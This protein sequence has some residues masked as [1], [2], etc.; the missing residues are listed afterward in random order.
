MKNFG[1]NLSFVA[2]AIA[3]LLTF[4]VSCKPDPKTEQEEPTDTGS[5]DTIRVEAP[6]QIID[7]DEGR[8]LY[9]KYDNRRVVLIERSEEPKP[10]GS[11]FD[12]ARYV[13]FDYKVIRQYLDYVDQEAQSANVNNIATL[14][15][16]FGNYADQEKFKDGK[17]VKH[18]RQNTIFML[19][20]VEENDSIWGFYTDAGSKEG[21]RIAVL[22]RG[23]LQTKGPMGAAQE[24]GMGM[25]E[26]DDKKAYAGFALPSATSNTSAPVPL[27]Q[28]GHSLIL[29]EGSSAP[30]P[31]N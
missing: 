19:P 10:D 7:L 26:E 17:P 30:P 20:T 3:L 24:Q 18:P 22:L 8:S 21:E 6:E 29:N 13:D 15:L 25:K 2:F 14:R 4:N 28:N 1:K 12:A 5:N 31:H 9:S 23:N 11:K 27:Y 16:Y